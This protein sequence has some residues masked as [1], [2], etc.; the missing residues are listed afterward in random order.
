MSFDAYPR[1]FATVPVTAGGEAPWGCSIPSRPELFQR[2]RALLGDVA[3][4][5]EPYVRGAKKRLRRRGRFYRQPKTLH[6]ASPSPRW[7]DTLR[8]G[9]AN[10][11][12]LPAKASP[13]LRG[14]HGGRASGQKAVAQPSVPNTLAN[15]VCRDILASPETPLSAVRSSSG[16]QT[17]QDSGVLLRNDQTTHTS[18]WGEARRLAARER[19]L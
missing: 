4:A 13:L 17:L 3:D 8:A 15:L 2:L 14:S 9:L 1:P 16:A 12:G 5:W 18:A 19:L 11:H 6:C 7:T 10:G